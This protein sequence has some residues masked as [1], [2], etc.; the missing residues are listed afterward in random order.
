M[1]DCNIPKL[2]LKYY[3]QEK[4][5]KKEKEKKLKNVGNNKIL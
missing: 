1:Y 4:E 3:P 2:I 5:K